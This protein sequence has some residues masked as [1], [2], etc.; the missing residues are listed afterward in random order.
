[1]LTT[2]A[3]D[4]YMVLRERVPAHAATDPTI[5]YA[6]LIDL[7]PSTHKLSDP[8]DHRLAQ[9]LGELVRLCQDNR[10]PLVS[11]LVV[12]TDSGMPGSGFYAIAYPG[13]DDEAKLQIA[14]AEELQR[15]KAMV[16]PIDR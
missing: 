12:R 9:A 14:W 6:K 2:L 16:Y 11:A 1:M 4:I 7:L 3:E 15:V 8:R 5:T 10:W 13:E